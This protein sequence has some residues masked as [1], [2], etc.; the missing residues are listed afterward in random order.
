MA[1]PKQSQP[2]RL[3]HI[4]QHMIRPIIYQVFTRYIT[5]LFF[6]LLWDFFLNKEPVRRP[7]STAF[8]LCT[9]FLAVMAW[10]AY[11]RLD[12]VR[13]PRFDRR[14]FQWKRKPARSYGD[15]IDYIDEDIPTFDDLDDEDKD[16]CLFLSNL[17][18]AALFIL[19]SI[20][21]PV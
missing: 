20:I 3:F 7:V 12:G 4:E 6:S 11:L 8:L 5:L 19:T 17:I 13:A 10:M 2:K 18:T 9:V 14:L 21:R 1:N 16:R 15:M